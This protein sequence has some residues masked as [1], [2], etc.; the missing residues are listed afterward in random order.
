MIEVQPLKKRQIKNGIIHNKVGMVPIEDSM[1]KSKLK[2]FEHV[3]RRTVDAI[4]R[5]VDKQRK[6]VTEEAKED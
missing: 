5:Q 1:C 6:F 4:M 3:K 2:W